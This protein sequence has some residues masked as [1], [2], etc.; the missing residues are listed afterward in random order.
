[1]S[2]DGRSLLED[3]LFGS[4]IAQVEIEL[5]A[6]EVTNM[7]VIFAEAAKQAPGPEASMLKIRGTEI[8]QAIT[9]LLVQ[10]VGPYA[11]PLRRDAMAAGYQ[12][13]ALGPDYAAPL[14][15]NY[16]NMRKLSIFG[17]SNEIQKNII[18]K[19]ILGI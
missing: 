5:T 16:L 12:G 4:K 13:S 2:K 11:L 17:G 14:A 10:A 15:A 3:P 19:L 18:A 7:R 9:E 1:M 6:L 8:Q